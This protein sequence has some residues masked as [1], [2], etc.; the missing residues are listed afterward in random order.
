MFFRFFMTKYVSIA[1]SKFNNKYCLCY[2][3]MIGLT[4]TEKYT[5]KIDINEDAALV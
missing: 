5:K 1:K 4:V 3:I 2:L